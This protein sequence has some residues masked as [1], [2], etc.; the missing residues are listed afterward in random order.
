M[1]RH[2]QQAAHLPTA[3]S[4]IA[5]HT[6]EMTSATASQISQSQTLDAQVEQ[7]QACYDCLRR[8]A[9]AAAASVS[10]GD[11][12]QQQQQQLLLLREEHID[13]L[14][15]RL[16]NLPASFS[17]L[18]ASQAW[19][20]YWSVHALYLLGEDLDDDI[21]ASLA[22]LLS[23]MQCRTTGG[24]G[25]GPHQVA[26]LAV[27]YAAVNCLCILGRLDLVDKPAMSSWL[28][29]LHQADGSYRMQVDGETDVRGVYC[30]VSVARLLN[31]PEFDSLFEGTAEWVGR[32]QTYEGGFGG[33]PG[34]EAHGGY[35]YCAFAALKL[36]NRTDACDC[37]R[38]LRWAATR[39][40]RFE[41]GFQG[42]TNKLVDS[43]Y[44]FW[45]SALFPALQSSLP[46]RLA[47]LAEGAWL[48]DQERLQCYVLAC[49]QKRTGGL[50]DK[51]PGSPDPYHCCYSL[52]GLSI[53]QHYLSGSDDRPEQSSVLLTGE[54]YNQLR[55]T[56][57]LHNIGLEFL[58]TGCGLSSGSA[59]PSASPDVNIVLDAD[60][61]FDTDLK[62]KESS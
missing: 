54:R 34:S 4:I 2:Q 60:T 27:T 36:L 48:F 62:A 3:S 58:P 20:A 29:S 5:L 56:C 23:T 53:A 17:G 32:C 22:D 31:L 12:Q 26:H 37:R 24:F 33:V 46:P 47:T 43:C 7:E 30:A 8:H 49:C 39:Q 19:L 14:T 51:P 35:A 11:Q 45:L 55:M 50:F 18:D 44:S 10:S 21:A 38:L 28:S 40:M 25:G 15:R 52:S 59:A 6:D 1:Q 42:R 13:Y 9:A 61:G 16:R 57:P 41:G